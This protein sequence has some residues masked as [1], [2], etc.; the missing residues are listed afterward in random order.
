MRL[1]L[2]LLLCL[3]LCAAPAAAALGPGDAFDRTLVF[4]GVERAYDLHVPAGYDGAT[5][6]P[7]V[8]DLH[9][10][11]SNRAQQRALSGLAGLSDAEGFA[12]AWP[13]GTN[14]SWNAGWCCG[15]AAMDGVHDVAFLRTLVD[16]IAGEVE[17]DRSRVYATGLS[18]GGALTQRLACEAADAF[19]AAAPFSFPIPLQ[20]IGA[21]APSRPIAVLAAQAP[22]DELVPY[23]GSDLFASAAASSAQWRANDGCGDGDPEQ[24]LVQGESR[25]E[26]DTSCEGGVEVGLCTIASTG[27]FGGHV[28]YWNEDFDLAQLAWGFLSRF[29]LPAAPPP[30]PVRVAG[31]KLSLRDPGAPE[32]RKL[33]LALRDEALAPGAAFDPTSDGARVTVYDTSGSGEQV[34]LAL[35]AAGWKRK[36]AGF[37]YRDP[38]QLA[39][40]CRRASVAPGRLA[41]A[42]DGRSVPLDYSLDEPTQGSVAARVESG[43]ES[44]CAEFGGRIAKD[45][46]GAAGGAFRASGAPAPAVCQ[47][48]VAPC[49]E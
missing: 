16:A 23:D 22:T 8:L 18:N 38:K 44:F 12:I 5:P 19:A 6:V 36:G 46:G 26:I 40:P 48:L 2:R 30:A 3:V 34:C 13:Q 49:P 31:K 42:C 25:C 10:F 41:L 15:Q 27:L 39:G 33:S 45:A 35:P 11:G 9:G 7:L 20:P 29:A 17:I 37:V 14:S 47:A 43:T 21:C 32:R 1:H 4:D 24:E 28:V